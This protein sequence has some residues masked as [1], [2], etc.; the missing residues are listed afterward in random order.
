MDPPY[1]LEGKPE[2]LYGDKGSTHRKFDHD[3]LF[4]MLKDRPNWLI[5]YGEHPE[6]LKRYADF[7]V[8]F[9][10]WNY[11]MS[12]DKS[13]REVL[14]LSK[15]LAASCSAPLQEVNPKH[16]MIVANTFPRKSPK[17]DATRPS[18]ASID[19]YFTQALLAKIEIIRR[20]V[21]DV[22]NLIVMSA[23][24]HRARIE[25]TTSLAA[26]GSDGA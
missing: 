23:R 25:T 8:A 19:H 14:I 20:P 22:S 2:N 13:S 11:A 10:E 6:I 18:Y 21:H 26:E 16:F 4:E 5:S 12:K 7:P 24:A 3:E 9:P 1:R 17:Y 15:D